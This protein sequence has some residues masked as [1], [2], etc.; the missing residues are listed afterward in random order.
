[1]NTYPQTHLCSSHSPYKSTTCCKWQELAIF[2]WSMPSIN[3]IPV[4]SMLGWIF[5]CVSVNRAQTHKPGKYKATQCFSQSF[6]LAFQQPY[7]QIPT[8]ISCL[9]SLAAVSSRGRSKFLRLR[10]R[11]NS[12]HGERTPEFVLQMFSVLK[13]S[14]SKAWPAAA[15]AVCT[16]HEDIPHPAT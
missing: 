5:S 10:F 4:A 8:S 6:H 2:S 11:N 3:T 7:S 1:M 13:C 9:L 12:V 15:A 16:L 14:F